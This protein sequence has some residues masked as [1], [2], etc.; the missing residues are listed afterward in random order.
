MADRFVAASLPPIEAAAHEEYEYYG[1]TLTTNTALKVTVVVLA[2]VIAGYVALRSAIPGREAAYLYLLLAV[3]VLAAALTAGTEPI[4]AASTREQ[5]AHLAAIC[6]FAAIPWIALFW[7]S[8]R[9]API[10]PARTGALVGLAAFCFALVEYRFLIPAAFSTSFVVQ[11]VMGGIITLTSAGAGALWLDV[12]PRWRKERSLAGTRA[13]SDIRAKFGARAAFPLACG[14]SIAA[15][16][17][18]LWNVRSSAPRVH[19][20]DLAI[21]KYQQSL[22]GFYPNVP[23]GSVQAVLTAYVEHGMPAYMWDFGPEGFKLVGGRLEHLP[24]GV[25][26][27]YTWFA[28]AKGGV[29]CMFRQIDG[30]KP[31]SIAHEERDHLLFYRYRGFS[32]CLINVGGY[33]NFISVIAAPIPMREFM[34]LVVKAVG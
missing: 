27:T 26:A 33:G 34:R 8:R 18:V 3:A 17:L 2:G 16:L 1:S 4:A 15:L 13:D 6:A 12:L 25:P 24:G 21:E 29:M 30:F 7:A 23:S 5:L 11:V 22:A 28:G 14:F 9:G 19:D 20:F 32:I 10:H 31:P